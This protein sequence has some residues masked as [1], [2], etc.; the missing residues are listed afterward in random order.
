MASAQIKKLFK[1]GINFWIIWPIFFG[2]FFGFSEIAL[3]TTGAPQIVSYQGRL[4]DSSGNLQT[5][6]FYFKFSIYDSSDISGGNR[7]WP[8]NAPTSTPITVSS[9]VFNVNIGDVANGY[10]T[11]LDYNFW[12]NADVFLQVAVSSN[13]SDFETLSPRQR[14]TSAGFA[15]NANAVASSTPGIGPNNILKL[16]SLG[17]IDISG[18]IT[19]TGQLQAG[20]TTT[21]QSAFL[22]NGL[23]DC[24][25][26]TNSKVI[27]DLATGKF[28]CGA[29]TAGAGVTV[30]FQNSYNGATS[31]PEILLNS[32]RGALTI[33]DAAASLGTNLLEVTNTS[34]S[35]LFAVAA[36]ST[37]ILN[38]SSTY[39]TI[40]DTAWV[41]NLTVTGTCTGCGA[42]GATSLQNAYNA[43]TSSPEVLLNSAIGVLTIQDAT[44]PLNT[45][46]F[47]I[48]DFSSRNL[49]DV[50]AT[51][52]TFLSG[53]YQIMRVAT[54]SAGNLDFAR[55]Q[56]GSAS[57]ES[58]VA[59]SRDQLY[60]F[61]RINS[62][63]HTFQQDIMGMCSPATALVA[64]TAAVCDQL[65]LDEFGGAAADGQLNTQATGSSTL[66]MKGGVSTSP[67]AGEGMAIGS[68][69]T[70]IPINSS[71]NPVF[72]ADVL[73]VQQAG[74]GGATGV[75]KQRIEV[76]FNSRGLTATNAQAE[77]T[78]G[79]Y[80]LAATST[81]TAGTWVAVAR[82]NNFEISATTTT[83]IS[84]TTTQK[85]RIEINSSDASAGTTT[86]RYFING[87]LAATISGKTSG[88]NNAIPES[89]IPLGYQIRTF[90]TG[91]TG[92]ANATSSVDILSM[93]VWY[94]DPPPGILQPTSAS[95]P[96]VAPPVFDAI[97]G[98]DIA[99]AY[100]S[101]DPDLFPP[102]TV[103]SIDESGGAKI[104]PSKKQYDQNLFGIVSTNPHTVLGQETDKT[105]R[106]AMNGRVPVRYNLENGFPN[107]G[108]WLTSSSEAG[109][110]MK[111]IKAGAVIG[112][113][114]ATSTPSLE[115]GQVLVAIKST[116]F[117]GASI[118]TF[119]PGL[120]DDR[121]QNFSNQV[122]KKLVSDQNALTMATS[123]LSELLTDRVVA[124]LEVITPRVTT[125]DLTAANIFAGE[126]N[127]DS[128]KANK[129]AGLEI[130]T[131]KITALGKKLDNIATTTAPIPEII[132][133]PISS[134]SENQTATSTVETNDTEFGVATT[135][136]T[137]ATS[138]VLALNFSDMVKFGDGITV[139][140]VGIFNGGIK[141]SNIGAIA[142]IF[143]FLSDAVF[144]GRPYFN[145]DM[146]GFA[147]IPKGAKSV[148]IAFEREYLEQPVINATIFI[149][150]SASSTPEDLIFQNNIQYLVTRKNAK[151]FT[152]LLN[153]EAPADIEF[154]WIVLA[155]KNAKIMIAPAT[156]AATPLIESES[157]LE[158]EMAPLTP[159]ENA[160]PATS[161]I[162]TAPLSE[163]IIATSSVE[164][165]PPEAEAALPPAEETASSTQAIIEQIPLTLPPAEQLPT[166]EQLIEQSP[167]EQPPAEQLPTEELPAT[168]ST[169]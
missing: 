10:P 75:F 92:N 136:P 160:A 117:S 120:T 162:E 87:Q 142:D 100:L 169:P 68:G 81:A 126:I 168:A 28:T 6:T 23:G 114:I 103:V 73:A 132:P 20:A 102:G 93:K 104:K 148:D 61:G 47:E 105:V 5:G 101:N 146:G 157:G 19:T 35:P 139:D 91:S 37:T 44:S 33:Q 108:D 107:V 155:V 27:Y 42:S 53:G 72:E 152:I 115:S 29:D 4:A 150:N 49:F 64:D 161:T 80:F 43:A 135:T 138:T 59:G 134:I 51:S 67:L 125:Q 90:V 15:L 85:L 26:P 2:L 55:V 17:Q 32:A 124:G 18:N 94:D 62:S 88:G 57:T 86:A 106:I 159:Q 154:S 133:L 7:L 137:A 22:Q 119:M 16:D 65:Y 52:T 166:E 89:I 56:I 98:A 123:T 39:M 163:T 129:I 127:A 122:L 46:L 9:G 36:T 3:S 118:A 40:G 34:G 96:E 128:I 69:S 66:R 113:V 131:D 164:L 21:L 63:W 54:S 141:V 83:V 12:D 24:D 25:D 78:N 14:I 112:Q 45:N 60:V 48:R 97:Q 95:N 111:A 58:N 31:S 74:G 8:I 121:S 156:T 110:A 158:S 109:V 165:T 116:Y 153:K 99:E 84:S 13:D 41:N 79:V 76:G 145:N 77:P 38:A 144:I 50:S 167:I 82:R 149:D 130:L 30:S 1:I 140:G 71:T 147:V 151:G 143:S 11:N 70:L